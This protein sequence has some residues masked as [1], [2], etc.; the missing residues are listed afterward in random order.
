MKAGGSNGQGQYGGIEG[1]VD[2]AH[3]G[4]GGGGVGSGMGGGG[5]LPGGAKE[6]NRSWTA[7]LSYLVCFSSLLCALVSSKASS[8]MMA[9][10]P[11]VSTRWNSKCRVL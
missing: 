3:A 10:I 1:L 11:C 9:K 4:V 2:A 8:S 5:A 7:R 6:C